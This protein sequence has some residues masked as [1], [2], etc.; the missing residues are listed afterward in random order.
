MHVHETRELC[1]PSP[2]HSSSSRPLPLQPVLKSKQDGTQR[3]L[4]VFAGTPHIIAVNVRL[5]SLQNAHQAVLYLLAWA[6]RRSAADLLP[7]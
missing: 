6:R 2:E 5:K 1:R 3:A 7:A 4:G